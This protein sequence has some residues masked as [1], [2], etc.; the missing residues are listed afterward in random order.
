MLRFQWGLQ[1]LRIVGNGKNQEVAVT[2]RSSYTVNTRADEA[3][4]IY[5]IRPDTFC[6]PFITEIESVTI[7]LYIFLSKHFKLVTSDLVHQHPAS[8]SKQWQPEGKNRGNSQT[9]IQAIHQ[10]G[11]KRYKLWDTSHRQKSEPDEITLSHQAES[12]LERL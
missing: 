2:Q 3:N 5:L 4:S 11:E 9:L 7:S 1:K 8:S 12:G 10:A 6:F